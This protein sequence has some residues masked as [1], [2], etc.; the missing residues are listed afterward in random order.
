MGDSTFYTS[1]IDGY[2]LSTYWADSIQVISEDHGTF[3]LAAHES[4]A[5]LLLHLFRLAQAWRD[6]DMHRYPQEALGDFRDLMNEVTAFL[7][8]EEEDA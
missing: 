2:T 4:G 8:E 3:F 7:M 1:G 5:N 6:G